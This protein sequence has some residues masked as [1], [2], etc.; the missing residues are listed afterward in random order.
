MSA[1]GCTAPWAAHAAPRTCPRLPA[2]LLPPRC[3]Q[4]CF[5]CEQNVT[6]PLVIDCKGISVSLP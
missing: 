4:N 3:A 1:P 6:E 5:L 2:P